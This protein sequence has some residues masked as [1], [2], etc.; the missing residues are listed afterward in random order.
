[1]NCYILNRFLEHKKRI[2]YVGNTINCINPDNGYRLL[3]L[4]D[5]RPV[6]KNSKKITGARFQ[7]YSRL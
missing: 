7:N 6:K 4:S 1:M 5:D 3:R 2:Q